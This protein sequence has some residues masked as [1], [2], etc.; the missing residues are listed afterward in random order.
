MT[1]KR[2]VSGLAQGTNDL[3]VSFEQFARNVGTAERFM[4]TAIRDSS[5]TDGG[6]LTSRRTYERKWQAAQFG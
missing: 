5:G 1:I 2:L 4:G 3:A 6:V